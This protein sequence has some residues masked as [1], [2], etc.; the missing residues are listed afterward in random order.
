MPLLSTRVQ[1]NPRDID[2]EHTLVIELTDIIQ[3]DRKYSGCDEEFLTLLINTIEEQ[4]CENLRL[5]LGP[6]VPVTRLL[7]A[8]FWSIRSVPKKQRTDA[9]M[10][11][12]QQLLHSGL[13]GISY[14]Q[15]D[16]EPGEV[17]DFYSDP[18]YPM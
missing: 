7:R 16:P 13:I 2:E 1:Y 14:I 5:G 17:P 12:E 3:Y 11:W 4:F 9:Y 18:T 8:I 10:K 6:K 15:E